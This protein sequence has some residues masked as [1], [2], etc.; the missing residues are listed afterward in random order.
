VVKNAPRAAS[1][2]GK[3][4]IIMRAYDQ[5]DGNAARRRLGLYRAGYQLLRTGPDAVRRC[6]MD[7]QVRPNADVRRRNFVYAD[8][9]K[10]GA[11]GETIFNYIITNNVDGDTYRKDILMLRLLRTACMFYACSPP[12]IL[13]IRL[14]STCLSRSIT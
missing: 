1:L 7:A 5:I 8:G 6:S 13:A 12:I 9:S 10:S 2:N 14:I 11:T 4:R 3:T